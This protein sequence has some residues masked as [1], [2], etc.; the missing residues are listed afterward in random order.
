M[1]RIKA[2][3]AHL[4]ISTVLASVVIALIVFGWYPPP[5]FWALGGPMLL[6]LLVGVDVVLGPLMTLILFN[7]KKSR[8]ELTL[9]LSLIGMVQLSAL[10]Y[11]LYSGYVGRVVYGAFA[12]GSFHVVEASEIAPD[13]LKQAPLLQ[14]QSLPFVGNRMIGTRVP[15]TDKAR[16]DVAFF[17]ALGVGPQHLPQFH[18]ELADNRDAILRAAISKERLQKVN[19]ALLNKLDELLQDNSLSWNDIAIVPFDMHTATYTTVVILKQ[20][21]VLKVLRDNPLRKE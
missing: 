21:Q 10:C 4:F 2:A 6:A 20:M 3:S 1:T 17:K 8:R 11:G 13:F 16:D 9:D 19:P 14:F 7:P 5:F 12:D 18:V 15:D